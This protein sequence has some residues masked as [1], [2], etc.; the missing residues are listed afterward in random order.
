MTQSQN[1]DYPLKVKK[2]VYA[3]LIGVL[4]THG[5][6]ISEWLHPRYKQICA[7][8]CIDLMNEIHLETAD[9]QDRCEKYNPNGFGYEDQF[10]KHINE[11]L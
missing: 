11:Y 9:A 1:K 3:D 6:D 8:G 7:Q 4:H 10:K 2:K 5:Y